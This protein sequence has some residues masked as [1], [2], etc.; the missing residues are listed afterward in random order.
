MAFNRPD[1]PADYVPP[2]GHIK[3]GKAD[4]DHGLTYDNQGKLYYF[5][6]PFAHEVKLSGML[7]GSIIF[8]AIA[9]GLGALAAIALWLG[10]SPAPEKAKKIEISNIDQIGQGISW[11][12]RYIHEPGAPVAHHSVECRPPPETS[13]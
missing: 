4:Y 8:G 9:T 11:E 2:E 6:T 7:N 5:G 13:D 12:C 10:W 1:S 3:L